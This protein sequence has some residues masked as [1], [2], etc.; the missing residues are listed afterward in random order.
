MDLEPYRLLCAALI[1]RA[2]QDALYERSFK[3]KC[4]NSK[5]KLNQHS[6]KAF[7]MSPY[8][9]MWV[10]AC[11]LRVQVGMI[12]KAVKMK[13]IRPFHGTWDY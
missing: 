5:H 1:H 10:R 7:L 2:F 8:L 13:R 12:R 4:L 3:Q 11:N 9:L 6:A